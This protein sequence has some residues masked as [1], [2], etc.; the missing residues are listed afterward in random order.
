MKSDARLGAA[1]AATLFL[2]FAA[3][4]SA[5]AADI[6][7]CTLL[8]PAQV[9]AA[10]GV[11]VGDGTHVTS[12]FVRTCTWNATGSSDVKTVTLLMQTAEGY[13][14]GKQMANQMAAGAKGTAVT[15]A[16]VGDDAYFFVTGDQPGL[17][18]KKGANSFKVTVYAKLPL[19][20]K[21]AMELALAKDVVAKI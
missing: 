19:E 20:K 11:P 6:D 13:D 7:A 1:C 8:T 10:V 21:E 14:R 4:P 12:T 5:A 3:L 16:R 9:G 17:L 18:V 15:P 2:G